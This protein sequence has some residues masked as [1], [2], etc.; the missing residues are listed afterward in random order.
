MGAQEGSV[1]D[2]LTS[3]MWVDESNGVAQ[4]IP[5]RRCQR[6]GVIATVPSGLS[7]AAESAKLESV[8]DT[9]LDS[10]RQRFV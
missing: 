6:W 4:R 7:W 5:L 9:E 3:M 10:S 2:I 1:L 8:A